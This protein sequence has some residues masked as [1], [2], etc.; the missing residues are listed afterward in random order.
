MRKA[1]KEKKVFQLK[2]EKLSDIQKAVLDWLNGYELGYFITLTPAFT[3]GGTQGTYSRFDY[4]KLFGSF[5]HYVEFYLFGKHYKTSRNSLHFFGFKEFGRTGA[6]THFHILTLKNKFVT[7]TSL[8]KALRYAAKQK[9]LRED[10]IGIENIYD[11]DGCIRYC[12]KEWRFQ[13]YYNTNYVYVNSEKL[14]TTTYLLPSNDVLNMKFPTPE[15]QN[16]LLKI[17]FFKIQDIKRGLIL[18]FKR[19][20]RSF[21]ATDTFKRFMDTRKLFQEQFGFSGSVLERYM[22]RFKERVLKKKKPKNL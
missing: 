12:I 22:S 5:M 9:G 19:M 10:C 16:E 15:E 1:K 18:N 3:D 20:A 4:N 13:R 6:F 7:K 17:R 11:Q 21:R 2:D 8:R 14:G